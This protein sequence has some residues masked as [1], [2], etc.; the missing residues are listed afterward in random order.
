LSDGRAGSVYGGDRLPW[1]QTGSHE[2]NYAS[3][4]LAWQAHL[5]GP[6]QQGVAKACAL[7]GLPLKHIAWHPNMRRT[8][9]KRGALYLI[10]PDGYIAM[11]I[12]DGN[13]EQ[14]VHYFKSRGLLPAISI[15]QD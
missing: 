13:P 11:A 2:D 7:L 9:I 1:V 12:P 8:G 15:Q 14:L 6:P 10:R 4:K 5:Y 3:L